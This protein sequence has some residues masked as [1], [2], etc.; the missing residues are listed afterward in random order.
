MQD[1]NDPN[2][3]RQAAPDLEAAM[4]VAGSIFSTASKTVAET[5]R[6]QFKRL[7]DGDVRFEEEVSRRYTE[8]RRMNL[9]EDQVWDTLLKSM[10]EIVRKRTVTAK[11][12]SAHETGK[13]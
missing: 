5:A 13:R 8:L 4:K 1:S 11:A 7:T 2:G 3:K 9:P 10:K 12:G 6:S